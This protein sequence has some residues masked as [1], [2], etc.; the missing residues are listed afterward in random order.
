MRAV[1]TGIANSVYGDINKGNIQQRNAKVA[2]VIRFEGDGGQTSYKALDFGT[3]RLR[4]TDHDSVRGAVRAVEG[5]YGVE[6][7]HPVGGAKGRVGG[8]AGGGGG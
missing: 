3:G 8:K 2:D 6:K 4:V 7:G 5:R 1:R